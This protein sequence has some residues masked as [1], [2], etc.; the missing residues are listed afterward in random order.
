M[1]DI[2]VIGGGMSGLT[3]AMAAARLG[4]MTALL[5]TLPMYGGQ[6][7]N[8]EE[9]EGLGDP[10]PGMMLAMTLMEQ[11][12]E[13]GV[14]IV[15]GEVTKI[16]P[17]DGSY[18]VATTG[19]SHRAK[20]VIVASGAAL[21]PLGVSG[22]EALWGR[23]VSQCASC[24]GPLF[25]GADVVVVGGGDA[26]AQEAL[27]LAGFC[28]T[29]TMLCRSGLKARTSYGERLAATENV[30][31]I[32]N[33]VVE[34]ILGEDGV[35]ALRVRDLRDGSNRE[36]ACAGV[37]PFIGATPNSGFVADCIS[38]D[39]GYIL[40]DD[41]Y[42]TSVDGIFAAGAVRKG[43]SGQLVDAISEAEAAARAA[44]Q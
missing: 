41:N 5:E 19:G 17:D 18:V 7:A 28:K 43:F 34:E 26:A 2:L 6:I 32:D 12:M 42:R 29:V 14:E 30:E 21:R 22:E 15:A 16:S 1:H 9:V 23:G 8:V 35:S 39:G 40:T 20:S 24:D 25:H 38:L 10:A 37:F 3:A 36:I 44:C 33:A 11:C 27:V 4:K 31:I 13:F